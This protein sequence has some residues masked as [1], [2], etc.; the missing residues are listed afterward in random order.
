MIADFRKRPSLARRKVIK[1]E[2]DAEIDRIVK[3]ELARA[4]RYWMTFGAT[5][6]RR[7]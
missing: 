3:E 5:D 6:P 1:A 2:K 4:T 7:S